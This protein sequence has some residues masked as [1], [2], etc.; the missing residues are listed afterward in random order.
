LPI[1][2]DG[3]I[4]RE[5]ALGWIADTLTNRTGENTGAGRAA[6][7]LNSTPTAARRP[8]KKLPKSG[9]SEVATAILDARINVALSNLGAV[10]RIAAKRACELG[11]PMRGAYALSQAI[12][13]DLATQAEGGIRSQDP[14]G[15]LN[16][17][18]LDLL[19]M[20][21]IGK[22]PNW[23]ALAATAGE[24]C[25]ED[26]WSEYVDQLGWFAGP[27]NDPRERP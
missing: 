14:H 17:R 5:T 9:L 7:L 27:E 23:A 19:E 10:A 13:I 25:D 18:T 21:G 16:A 12:T 8:A 22:E 11:I 26:A 2:S 24:V 4:D 20:L 1:R 3:K 15:L 6:G